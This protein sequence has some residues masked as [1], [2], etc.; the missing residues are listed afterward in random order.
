[1]TTSIN[2]NSVEADMQ[3]RYTIGI[4]ISK[5]RL[6][7]MSMDQGQVFHKPAHTSNSVE[8]INQLILHW[9]KEGINMN[10]TLV[11]FEHTGVYGM[12][13]AMVLEQHDIRYVM[14]PAQ[15]VKLSLGIQRGKSDPIDATRL[16]DYAFTHQH[17]LTPTKL[18]SRVLTELRNW[19]VWRE[20][21]VKMRTAVS[22]ACKAQQGLTELV[23]ADELFA[24]MDEY[25]HKLTADIAQ[26][27]TKLTDILN[28][29]AKLQNMYA[30]LTS[31][32]GIGKITA[33]WLL[34]YTHG[35]TRFGSS[36]KLS[37]YI[38]SAPFPHR[39]GQVNKRDRVSRIRC[40]RLKALLSNGAHSASNYDPEI[41][42]YYKRKCEE[43][44]HPQSVMNAVVCKLIYRAYAVI[45][46]GT[47]YVKTYAH[48][49]A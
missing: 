9:K 12:P 6:D 27:E 49:M 47:P 10:S 14:V 21:L 32:P 41:R 17:K 8:A 31:I 34:V 38:G 48:S 39:S 26:T 35:F 24:N 42:Q 40:S 18:P 19:L 11:C 20:Q 25:F 30:L 22:N 23:S 1:M 45:K 5:K 16:A 3:F 13:L 44:K 43:G 36:R 33:C 29:E 28:R 2:S 46:R 4:D 7:W 15:Q 37:C